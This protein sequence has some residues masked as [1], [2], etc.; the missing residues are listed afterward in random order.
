MMR[1]C[2]R[3]PSKITL[4]QKGMQTM[5]SYVLKTVP[6]YQYQHILKATFKPGQMGFLTIAVMDFPNLKIQQDNQTFKNKSY[7]NQFHFFI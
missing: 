4:Q 7:E 2:F 1:N 5:P 3:K 6:V